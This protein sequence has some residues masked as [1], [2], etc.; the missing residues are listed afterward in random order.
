M[1]N[2]APEPS[3]TERA[4]E[5][6]RAAKVEV[7]ALV[8]E[9]QDTPL[10]IDSLKESIRGLVDQLGSTNRQWLGVGLNASMTAL[11]I[12]SAIAFSGWV[13]AAGVAWAVVNG[14]PLALTGWRWLL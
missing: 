6:V 11:G 5:A 13:A 2:G 10:T 9:A 1:S 8:G 4:R 7:A 14:Y 12:Y 3:I